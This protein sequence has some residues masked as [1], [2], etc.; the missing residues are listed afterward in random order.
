MQSS[1]GWH[2][3]EIKILVV[4]DEP[5]A[6][7]VVRKLLEKTGYTGTCP[8]PPQRAARTSRTPHPVVSLQFLGPARIVFSECAAPPSDVHRSNMAALHA[9]VEVV[10]SGRKATELIETKSFNLVLCD[11]HMPDIDGADASAL[12]SGRSTAKLWR[13]GVCA[14]NARVRAA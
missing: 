5:T 6:R 8:P 7:L 9:E 13:S 3:K 10:E 4:D 1:L 12:L 11:L 2:P 14:Y